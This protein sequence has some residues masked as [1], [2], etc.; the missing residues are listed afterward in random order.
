MFYPAWFGD[1]CSDDATIVTRSVQGKLA[2]RTTRGSTY[3]N[4][5]IATNEASASSRGSSMV[6]ASSSV[7]IAGSTGQV[8]VLISGNRERKSNFE[9]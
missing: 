6:M 9:V 4:V 1:C 8:A 7:L 5:P 2:V 3:K